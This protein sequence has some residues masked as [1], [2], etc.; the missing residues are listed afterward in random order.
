VAAKKE[1]SEQNIHPAAQHHLNAAIRVKVK[2][3]V[4]PN[5]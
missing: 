4:K 1:K 2:N 3:G 5:K